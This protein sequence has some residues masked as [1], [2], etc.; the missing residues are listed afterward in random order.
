[1]QSQYSLPR[2]S[3]NQWGLSYTHT[4]SEGYHAHTQPVRAIMHTHNQWG[5]SCTHTTSEGYHA[6]TQPV[7]AIIHTHNQ[8][9]LS[10]TLLTTDNDGLTQLEWLHLTIS[11]VRCGSVNTVIVTSLD[12]YTQL[13]SQCHTAVPHTQYKFTITITFTLTKIFTSH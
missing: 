2:G 10:Y 8:W 13:A 3:Y 7:R 11:F 9:G 4:T 1:M 5:L 12:K 6:H